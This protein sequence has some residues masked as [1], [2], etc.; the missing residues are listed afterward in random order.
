MRLQLELPDGPATTARIGRSSTGKTL[1]YGADLR[2]CLAVL[3]RVVSEIESRE[4]QREE[5]RFSWLRR[6]AGVSYYLVADG[7]RLLAEHPGSA[8]L[9]ALVAV[10]RERGPAV[11]VILKT[12]DAVRAR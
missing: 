8:E 1:P 4:T 2:T 5:Q 7:D 3:H 9:S 11:G 12:P 10:V 6:R